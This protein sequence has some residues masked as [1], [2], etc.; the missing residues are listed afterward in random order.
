MSLFVFVVAAV[1]YLSVSA[2]L[3]VLVEL[4]GLF[5]MLSACVCSVCLSVC[6]FLAFS[7]VF[8]C[9]SWNMSAFYFG[10]YVC[11]RA[12]RNVQECEHVCVCCRLWGHRQVLISS[13]QTRRWGGERL[14]AECSGVLCSSLQSGTWPWA[15]TKWKMKQRSSG[16]LNVCKSETD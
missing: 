1:S 2:D 14:G 12:Y 16:A 5:R 3:F 11:E 4:D 15:V 7:C 13:D 9:T 10:L 8:V 6:V